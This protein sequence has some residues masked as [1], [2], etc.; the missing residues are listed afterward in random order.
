MWRQDLKGLGG[1]RPFSQIKMNIIDQ[2]RLGKLFGVKVY[3]VSMGRHGCAEQTSS[4]STTC[5]SSHPGLPYNRRQY[6]SGCKP[7][8]ALWVSLGPPWVPRVLR[9][10]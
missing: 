8:Y 3:G 7:T 4:D 10:P 6:I 1:H 2:R 9:I 5:P